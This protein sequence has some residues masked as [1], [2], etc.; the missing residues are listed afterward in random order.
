[1]AKKNKT[2]HCTSEAQKRAIAKSYAKRKAQDSKQEQ[3][4]EKL[5]MY[6]AKIKNR[7]FY[8]SDKGDSTHTY[9]VYKDSISEEVRAVP[10]THLYV[11]DE[12]NMEKLHK[13]L[14][15]KVNLPGYET[16]S[17]VHNYYYNQNINGKQI[18]LQDNDI[19]VN[20][21]PLDQETANQIHRF[22]KTV[23]RP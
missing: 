10:T 7:Y 17:G 1:M 11:P 6:L 5:D 2:R 9:A 23:H 22:A 12:K 21:T 8:K 20:G 3:S 14:L 19:E 13:G 18:N 4:A 15:C 16:P